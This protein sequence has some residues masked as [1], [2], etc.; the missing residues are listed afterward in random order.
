MIDKRKLLELLSSSD[1]IIIDYYQ[2]DGQCSMLKCFLG[3]IFEFILIYIPSKLRFSLSSRS[4]NIYTLEHLEENTDID[5]YAKSKKNTDME[6]IDEQKSID[7]YTDLTRKYKKNIYTEGDD[8]PT[9]R[10]VRRQ[11]TR[12]KIPFEKLSYDIAIQNGRILAVS[13][14]EDNNLFEIKGYPQGGD[15]INC[16]M[17][18]INV[19]DLIDNLDHIP[20]EIDIIRGQFYNILEKVSISNFDSMI[21][22]IAN[23]SDLRQKMQDKKIKYQTYSAEYKELF[24]NIKTKE[25]ITFK[26]YK[27]VLSKT[28]DLVRKTQIETEAQKEL[29]EIFKNKMDV[30]DKGIMLTTKY[31]GTI[32][33]LETTAFDNCVMTKRVELNFERLNKAL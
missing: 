23:Y 25:D 30:I 32:L 15:Q 11:I 3:K 4:K 21:H 7:I 33:L 9:I 14:G 31:H 13:F 10:K 19:K 17:Y 27:E 2:I 12:L 18:V 29:N 5:D 8:E 6:T 24:Q 16:L 1:I 22:T 28:I 26:K 20:E